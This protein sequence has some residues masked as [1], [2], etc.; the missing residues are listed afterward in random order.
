SASP[1]N[2]SPTMTHSPWMS[3]GSSAGPPV[4]A[5]EVRWVIE[6]LRKLTADPWDIR[7]MRQAISSESVTAPWACDRGPM[8]DRDVAEVDRRSLG[9]QGDAAAEGPVALATIDPAPIQS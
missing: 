6:T 9:H 8:G 4:A 7:A 3:P 2:P 1:F 5:T